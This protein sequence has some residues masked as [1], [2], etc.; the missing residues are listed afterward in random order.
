MVEAELFYRWPLGMRLRLRLR[1][2]LWAGLR[3]ELGGSIMT[4]EGSTLL[5]ILPCTWNMRSS[6]LDMIITVTNKRSTVSAS[7]RSKRE[8]SVK[9]IYERLQLQIYDFQGDAR[10]VAHIC[11]VI[12]HL[13]HREISDLPRN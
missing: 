5:V 3:L 12:P 8:V 4:G 6:S 1:L 2:R 11:A 7:R 10:H 13:C 9:S